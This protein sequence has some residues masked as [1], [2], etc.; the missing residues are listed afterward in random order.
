M[1]EYHTIQGIQVAQPI[2]DALEQ[3]AATAGL[4]ADRVWAALARAVEELGPENHRLLAVRDELQAKIDSYHRD[5]PPMEGRHAQGPYEDFLREIGYLVEEPADFAIDPGAV[6]PEIA[7]VAGPQL[8][9]PAT[10]PRY[11]LN[12]ANARWGSLY[13]AAYGSDLIPEDDGLQK[14]GGYNPARGKA[15]M[16][17]AATVLDQ[18]APLAKGSHADV[19]AYRVVMRR[20]RLDLEMALHDGSVVTLGPEARFAGARLR[21]GTDLESAGETPTEPA[22]VLV[23]RHG[24]HVELVID[25]EHPVGREHPAGVADVMMEAAVTTI[26]D[27]EDSVAIVDAEDKAAAYVTLLELFRGDLEATFSKGDVRVTRRL[28]PDRHYT[29]PDGGSLTL[30]GRSLLL[31]RNVGSLMTTDA[32]LDAA[33]QP[34]HETFL[35]AVAS[36]L[37]ALVDRAGVGACVNSRAGA[38]YIVKP[39]MHGPAEVAFH[40]RLLELV[41]DELDLPTGALKMGVMD[42]ERRTTLNL[43]A[44]VHAARDRIIFINTG[45]LDRTGD[46]IHTDMEAGPVVRKAAMKQE[47]WIA[48]YEDQNV[49]V[50]L[51]C[52]FMGRGQIGK[53]MWAKPDSMA[54]MVAVKGEH[55]EAGADCAWAPSPTAATLHAIHYHQVDVNA[56]QAALLAAGPRA[57]RRDLLT[58]PLMTTTPAPHAVQEEVDANVQAILGYVVRW[59]EMG[60]GCSKVPDLGGVGLMEDRATLRIASQLLANWLRHGVVDETLLDASLERMAAVVDSQN[61]GEHGYLPMANDPQ[62]SIAFQAAR[63]LIFKGREQPNGYTEP[64]LHAAR[65]KAKA[66]LLK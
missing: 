2:R 60:V 1:M 12:A 38:M 62:R 63:D 61:A 47:P 17:F 40:C 3:A 58:L 45:F 20:G 50:G 6:D 30:P 27:L 46:E 36:G 37:L 22:A 29:A 66:A 48:A 26:L 55:P 59:V 33:G 18:A 64:I 35:D 54:E 57:S 10:I 51:A 19:A 44:C 8:V 28:H 53:G 14:T 52:G 7:R 49:D 56:R 31:I 13:D 11:V 42:E 32:V 39:K 43:K 23:E 16:D 4:S 41:E 5:N 65:R 9:V 25:R 34:V 21:E 15:V 24:L